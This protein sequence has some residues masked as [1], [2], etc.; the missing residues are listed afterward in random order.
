MHRIVWQIEEKLTILVLFNELDRLGRESVAQKFILRPVAKRR[1]L[2]GRKIA[3]RLAPIIAGDIDVKP[4]FL[5]PVRFRTEVPF[6][7]A[8]GMIDCLF[9]RCCQIRNAGLELHGPCGHS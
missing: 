5:R 3:W 8:G 2:I 4:E 9:E 6:S 1:N 7:D